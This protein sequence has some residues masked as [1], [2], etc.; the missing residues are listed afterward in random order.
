[1]TDYNG[2]YNKLT[3]KELLITLITRDFIVDNCH[4]E[5]IQLKDKL[6]LTEKALELACK[7]LA[8]TK[9]IDVMVQNGYRSGEPKDIEKHFKSQAE[10]EMMKSETTK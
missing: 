7:E 6:A 9:M 8:D 5:N 10:K 4:A 2:I 1:M 3:K